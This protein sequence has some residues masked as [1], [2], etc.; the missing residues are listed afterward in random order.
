M[1]RSGIALIFVLFTALPALADRTVPPPSFSEP[2]KSLSSVQRITLPSVDLDEI[3]AEDRLREMNGLAPRYAIPFA[4][5]HSPS[6]S[7]TWENTR[8]GDRLWRLRVHADGASS[9]NFGFGRYRM[10]T[11]GRLY[12]YGPDGSSLRGPFTD[13]DNEIHGQLWTPVVAGNEAVIELVLPARMTPFLDLRLTSINYGYKEFWL[14]SAD[15]SGSCNIDVACQDG[16]EWRDEVRSVAV[17]STGGRLFCSGFLVNNVA[18]DMIPYFMTAKHCGVSASKAPSLVVYWNYET[19]TC[20]GS[21]DGTLGQYQTGST[22]R[23]ALSASDF[24]LVELDDPPEPGFNVHWSGWDASDGDPTG[25]VAIHHP[26]TDEKRITFE[27]DPL[28]TTSFMGT[29]SPGQGTH[30]RVE[31]WDLGTTEPGSSGSGLWN[32]AHRIVGQLHGGYAACG[33]ELA[34]WYGRFS[35]SWDS[36]DSPSTRLR[37][38]LDPDD[39]GAVTVDGRDQCDRPTVEF[40]SSPSPGVVGE[41]VAFTS[42]VGGGAP[43]YTYAWDVDG[44]GTIDYDTADPIHVYTSPY[45]GN[46]RLSVTDSGMCPAYRSHHMGVTSGVVYHIGDSYPFDWVDITGTGLPLSLGDDGHAPVEIP[47]SFTFFGISHTSISIGSDGYIHFIDGLL[48]SENQPIPSEHDSG[49]EAIIAVFWDDLDPGL[50]GEIF[51]EIRGEAPSRILIVQWSEIPLGGESG[52]V[53][54]QALLEEETSDILFQYLDVDAGDPARDLG[55]SATVGL[56]ESGIFGVEYSYNLPAL[57]DGHVILF[58]EFQCDSEADCDDGIWCNG[59]EI[60]EESICTPGEEPCAPVGG[61]CVDVRCSEVDDR[62]DYQCHAIDYLDPCCTALGCS[63]DPVCEEPL[64]I[65]ADGDGYGD[66]A[67]PECDRSDPDCD[68]SNSGIHPGAD[69]VCDN[70]ADDDCDGFVDGGDLDCRKDKGG[71]SCSALIVPV[72]RVPVPV[73]LIPALALVII[74]RRIAKR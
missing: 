38:W 49:I 26:R 31:D 37:D 44:D 25:A 66:P 47:F 46:V 67:R 60:C 3:R 53:S 50:G 73:C 5:S 59:R 56:Q 63:E 27:H 48:P 14:P 42:T 45:N 68:D 70:G 69:E 52:T 13:E 71:N 16:D 74:I 61:G 36:G 58:T 33:N 18:G 28:S 35:V 43:P 34:D 8:S 9:L 4:V 15:R 51:Y 2:V 12:I 54:F 30:L 22:F 40:E 55:A 21:P 41:P 20:G 32:Q 62:C 24:T 65:D 6:T 23:A 19:S 1:M 10:P 11:G 17:I 29:S 39:T 64:C 72:S 57:S 7:G